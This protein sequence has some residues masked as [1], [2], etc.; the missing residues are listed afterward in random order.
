MKIIISIYFVLIGLLNVVQT[1]GVL[2]LAFMGG[3]RLDD[4]RSILAFVLLV[5]TIFMGCIFIYIGIKFTNLLKARSVL[6]L[7]VV[8]LSMLVVLLFGF[9]EYSATALLFLIA[10]VIICCLL[11]YVFRKQNSAIS[12]LTSR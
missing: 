12:S 4:W 8:P 6:F 7:L 3:L 1:S 11:V 2:F 9:K 5:L 10:H